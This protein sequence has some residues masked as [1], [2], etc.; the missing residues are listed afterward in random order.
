MFA[1]DGARDRRADEA[2]ADD[3]PAADITA[4]ED[5]DGMF[6]R[7]ERSV[8]RREAASGGAVAVF[9]Y[10]E[11]R[12]SVGERVTGEFRTASRTGSNAGIVVVF[13]VGV[14]S[15]G[16]HEDGGAGWVGEQA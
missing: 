16:E 8:A 10:D 5:D 12:G 11:R 7:T 4:A 15:H 14:G 1:R 2:D 6:S 9:S 3:G 13:G